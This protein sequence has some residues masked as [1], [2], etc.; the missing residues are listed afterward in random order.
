M[1]KDK[2]NSETYVVDQVVTELMYPFR[3]PRE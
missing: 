1:F 3:D 2:V